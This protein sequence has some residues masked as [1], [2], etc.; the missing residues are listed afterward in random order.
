MT[1]NSTNTQQKTKIHTKIRTMYFKRNSHYVFKEIPYGDYVLEVHS[2]DAKTQ[3]IEVA[4]YT[5]EV[6][7]N[8]TLESSD[9]HE[10][11][12][13]MLHGKSQKITYFA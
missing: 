8:S 7:K 2:I 6:V 10:L 9:H 5:E 1:M 3:I 12:E 13:V 4:L 11:N